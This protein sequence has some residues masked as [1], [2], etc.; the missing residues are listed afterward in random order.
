MRLEEA[1]A[2][3][4][5]RR[6]EEIARDRALQAHLLVE[7]QPETQGK[8]AGEIVARRNIEG[9]EVFDNLR[10]ADTFAARRKQESLGDRSVSVEME[11][12][13]QTLNAN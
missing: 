3:F 7:M 4:F 13:P 9:P 10:P 8:D 2:D 1:D 6:K 12:R 11:H 5:G